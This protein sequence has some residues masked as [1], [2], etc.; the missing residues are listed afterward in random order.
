MGQLAAPTCPQRSCKD[1]PERDGDQPDEQGATIQLPLY[2]QRNA[3]CFAQ[4]AER[5][6]DVKFLASRYIQQ[7]Q[8]GDAVSVASCLGI[9]RHL[10]TCRLAGLLNAFFQNVECDVSLLLVDD[11][12]RAEAELVSPQPRKSR[13]RSK[14][15]STMRSR[16]AGGRFVALV[17][18]DL[19]ADHQ[20]AAADVADQWDA[21]ATQVCMRSSMFAPTVAA[22][23]RPSRSKSPWWRVRR[24][25]RRGCRRR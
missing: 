25:C 2:I 18:H 16:W 17:V 6:G 9:A 13:P 1:R 22:F 10:L 14:A 19:D 11:E 24:R 21:S 20:A 3:L 4:G 12:R 5:A 7:K 8:R 23:F 15:S